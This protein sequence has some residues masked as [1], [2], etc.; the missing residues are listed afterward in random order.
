[1]ISNSSCTAA[2]TSD[3]VGRVKRSLDE[4]EKT[5]SSNRRKRL[6]EVKARARSLEESGLL[7]R[8]EYAA[9]STADFERR[10]VTPRASEVPSE[11]L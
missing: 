5:V 8:Q 9:P 11:L 1:M 4:S 6:E 7:K 2:V 3:L 10:F